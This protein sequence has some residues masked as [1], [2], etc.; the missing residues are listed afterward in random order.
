[1]RDASSGPVEPA[2]PN[3]RAVGDSAQAKPDEGHVA[4]AVL[5]QAHADADAVLRQAHVDADALLRRAEAP[6]EAKLLQAE[7]D[8]EATLRRAEIPAAAK[9]LQAEV[10]AEATLRRAEIPAAAK[11]L[12]AEVDA[13]ATL[14][15]VD[16][17]A[18][19]ALPRA[20]IDA[21]VAAATLLQAK[22][23]AEAALHRAEIPAAAK[24]LQAEVDAEATLRRAELP[25]AAKLLQAAVDAEATLR[26][27][28]IPAAA[29]LLQAE[30]DAE[31]VFEPFFALATDMMCISSEGSY[32]HA[33]P[34]FGCLGYSCEE[35]LSRPIL[36]LVHPDDK[37]LT[38]AAYDSLTLEAP[39]IDFENRF[40]GKDGAY[41]WLSWA[42][43]LDATG[44]VYS[45]ARDI[46]E[47]KRNH[48][49]LLRAKDAV[50]D[51]NR[52]LESFS[53]S[54]AHDLRA[55]L[56]GIAGF[57]RVL[58]EDYVEKL[59]ATGKAYLTFIRES[60]QQMSQL[61][62]DL[63]GLSRITHGELRFDDVE[64][65]SLARAVTVRLQNSQPERVV[66]MLI[67]DGLRDQG[68]A[69]LLSV[70]LDNLLGNAWKFTAKRADA[71]IEFGTRSDG[72][73][74]VY[75]LRDNGAGFDMASVGNL[76]KVFQR[77]HAADEFE[78]TGVGLATV[79]RIVSR[80]GGRVWAEGEVNQGATFFFTLHEPASAGPT[81]GHKA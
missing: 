80:H 20:E 43:G 47:S 54:V 65:S 21:E 24:L 52:E 44:R 6:A 7:V 27:A 22:V 81:N 76:F 49:A 9:L 68:D 73:Q 55:P 4:D 14:R 57:S 70:V 74:L 19:M 11:L 67:Q 38:Q 71:R 12:Q 72:G 63:L 2:D 75:F 5:R 23:D 61:I 17:S 30:V 15:R 64:L 1:M 78:G 13:E 35:M 18:T 31:D 48:K 60:A 69:R 56:R 58:L 28:E 46:T 37:A 42:C 3:R 8:A 29:K 79:Q 33:S 51:A 39:S 50:Q 16:V 53:Y 36:D 40:R 59:D 34:S 77:L 26:R 41:R 32:T 66:D 62:A 45:M 10:D 25:A